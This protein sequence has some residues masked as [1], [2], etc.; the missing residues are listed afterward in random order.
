MHTWQLLYFR[1]I[2]QKA[3]E[4]TSLSPSSSQTAP[5]DEDP[6]STSVSVVRGGVEGLG[7]DVRDRG[8]ILKEK[9]HFVNMDNVS[10]SYDA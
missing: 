9:P 3:Q 1:T 8:D 2:L 7:G 6:S 10:V 5:S 4:Q